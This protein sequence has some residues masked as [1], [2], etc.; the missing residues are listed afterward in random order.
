[1]KKIVIIADTTWSIGRIHKD[2]ENAL[3]DKYTFIFYEAARFNLESFMR[4]FKEANACI[5]TYSVYDAFIQLINNTIELRKTLIV[6]HGHSEYAAHNRTSHTT[7]MT[8]ASTSHVLKP[9]FGETPLYITPN[10]VD[11]SQFKYKPHSGQINTLGWCGAIGVATKRFE[12]GCKIA[13]KT[14]LPI[15]Y[16]ISIPFEK[17]VEWYQTIDV[18]VV[19]AGPE[20]YV[21]TGPLPPFEAIASGCL[22]IGTSVGNFSLVP[23]P[24]FKTIE[25]A[26]EIINS[27]RE[28]PEECKR[29]AA[30]QYAYVIENMDMKKVSAEWDKAICAT[31]EK[32]G[33]A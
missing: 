1:M 16:A 15:S 19:T 13:A 32:A 28:K 17:V 26:V 11:C 7:D 4:D 30:E 10:A 2:L 3:K 23:G 9:F 33:T 20:E 8:Y 12:W 25:E 29:I 5:T 18:L 24:K 6:C 22:V 31:M 21:E 14:R 27:L